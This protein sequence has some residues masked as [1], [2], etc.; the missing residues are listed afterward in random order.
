MA[1]TADA[2]L[3]LLTLYVNCLL[4]PDICGQDGNS[5]S[6]G[7]CLRQFA[8]VWPSSLC[9][10]SK[11]VLRL[12]ASDEEDE[13]IIEGFETLLEEDDVLEEHDRH[14]STCDPVVGG[15]RWFKWKKAELEGM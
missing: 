7:L 10:T 2:D 1:N 15:P 9:N 13:G 11:V 5:N 3:G 4:C 12:P 14:V 8:P 6:A